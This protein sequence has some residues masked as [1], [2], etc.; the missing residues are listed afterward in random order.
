MVILQ[1]ITVAVLDEMGFIMFNSEEYLLA[2]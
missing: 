2:D 1:M